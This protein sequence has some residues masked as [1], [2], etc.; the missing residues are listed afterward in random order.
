MDTIGLILLIIMV[1]FIIIRFACIPNLFLLL[2]NPREN[3]NNN[4]NVCEEVDENN[5]IN[6]SKER[7][8][9]LEDCLPPYTP[10]NNVNTSRIL[11]LQKEE[12]SVPEYY[13]LSLLSSPLLSST[14]ST[15]ELNGYETVININE[16]PP[17][18]SYESCNDNHEESIPDIPINNDT[19]IITNG[20]IN[21]KINF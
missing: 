21:N 2:D 19:D 10:L 4:D 15:I 18:P 7:N 3:I 14:I 8:R 16:L 5:D 17:P 20:S 1:L 9:Q 6:E 12:S 11:S 13:S